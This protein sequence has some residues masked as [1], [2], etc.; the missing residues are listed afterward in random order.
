MIGIVDVSSSTSRSITV[1][2]FTEH[3]LAIESRTKSR[4]NKLLLLS[5]LGQNALRRSLIINPLISIQILHAYSFNIIKKLLLY[6]LN[7]ASLQRTFSTFL[8]NNKGGGI[9]IVQQALNIKLMEKLS[10]NVYISLAFGQRHN[11]FTIYKLSIRMWQM[12]LPSVFTKYV[13][14]IEEQGHLH[15]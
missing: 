11:L 7:S 15:Q 5:L 8:W 12:L 9:S 2:V 6:V 3:E 14:T 13:S 10:T 4:I 1:S